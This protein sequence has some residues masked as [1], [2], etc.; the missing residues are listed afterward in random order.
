MEL[1]GIKEDVIW[2]LDALKIQ[3]FMEFEHPSYAFLTR[4]FHSSVTIAYPKGMRPLA[5]HGVLSFR[6]LD[7]HYSLTIPQMDV[8]LNF[9]PQHTLLNA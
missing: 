4:K 8:S 6:I 1:L 2:Y 9:V 3:T 5:T 7:E